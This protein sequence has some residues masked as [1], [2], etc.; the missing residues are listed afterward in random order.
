MIWQYDNVAVGYCFV[1]KTEQ[2]SMKKE[3]ES[4]LTI[5]YR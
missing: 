4:M 2:E 3:K 1:L 5:Y